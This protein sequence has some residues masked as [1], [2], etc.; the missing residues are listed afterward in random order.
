MSDDRDRK[1]LDDVGQRRQVQDV[2][3]HAVQRSR[4]PRAVAVPAQIQ[5]IDVVVV[6]QR[7]RYPVP[8]PCVVEPA[9]H[10]DHGGLSI[11]APVPKLK[12]QT[13]RVEEMRDRL[14]AAL[15]ASI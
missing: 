4:R 3:G 12:L 8:V 15:E 1:R 7:P 2:L 10:Q 14:Q 5:R 6:S 11:R 9:M 13:M